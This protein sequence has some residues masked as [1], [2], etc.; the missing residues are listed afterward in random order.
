MIP[1]IYKAF[2]STVRF[3]DSIKRVKVSQIRVKL[4]NSVTRTHVNWK[5]GPRNVTLILL[6]QK[7][8]E[9]LVVALVTLQRKGR[10]H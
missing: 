6:L 2:L 5:L 4:S 7:I 9:D 8:Q 1:F 10:E 3:Q